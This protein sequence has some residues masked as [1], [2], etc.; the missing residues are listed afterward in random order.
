M[1][2][3]SDSTCKTR[4][5]FAP[6]LTT[7]G[8]ACCPMPRPLLVPFLHQQSLAIPVS[9]KASLQ[10]P[11]QMVPTK[12]FNHPQWSSHIFKFRTR[13]DINKWLRVW[14]RGRCIAESC[15]Q[16]RVLKMAALYAPGSA[17]PFP[18]HCCRASQLI[19][20]ANPQ[21]LDLQ[22]YQS[23]VVSFF[24]IYT[25]I[26]MITHVYRYIILKLYE[27]ECMHVCSCIMA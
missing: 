18:D 6:K 17:N 9:V 23:H 3:D 22:D 13:D 10:H 16:A 27:Y 5:V 24:G 7:P 8:K 4:W 2:N 12:H 20:L 19:L 26:H 25:Y 21:I 11:G 14:S 1:V 15:R